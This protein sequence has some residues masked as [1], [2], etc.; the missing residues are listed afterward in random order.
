MEA[1][2]ARLDAQ[3]PP[4][5]FPFLANAEA[6]AGELTQHSLPIA[7]Q[8]GTLEELSQMPP[9]QCAYALDATPSSLLSPIS[10]LSNTFASTLTLSQAP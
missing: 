9:A 4:N 6:V 1:L 7:R 5:L 10:L 2:F 8:C 3:C